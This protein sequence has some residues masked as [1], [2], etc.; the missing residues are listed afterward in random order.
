MRATIPSALR[1][2]ATLVWC[3][4]MVFALAF[5]SRA[6]AAEQLVTQRDDARLT[7]TDPAPV[8]APPPSS[9]ELG[10][11]AE[12]ESSPGED[13]SVACT[14]SGWDPRA[15]WELVA[16]VR[17]ERFALRGSQ[18]LQRCRHNRGPPA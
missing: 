16:A 1:R 14:T 4:A 11:D 9:A 7:D 12:S 2:V 3:L 5:G 15:S 17:A 10:E 6:A 13:D 8:L 18:S